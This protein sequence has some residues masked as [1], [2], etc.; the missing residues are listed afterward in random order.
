MQQ[1][2]VSPEPTLPN[3]VPAKVCEI[4]KPPQWVALKIGAGSIRAYPHAESTGLVISD[5]AKI[6]S[7]IETSKFWGNFF[8]IR[9]SLIFNS[10]S[11]VVIFRLQ[12]YIFNLTSAYPEL[13]L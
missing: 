4:K 7:F 5:A 10:L 12:S 13:R 9:G 6:G 11:S 8:T 1:K 2:V 3:T